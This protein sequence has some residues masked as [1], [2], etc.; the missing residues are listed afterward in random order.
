MKTRKPDLRRIIRAR[1]REARSSSESLSSPTASVRVAWSSEEYE[2]AARK[3]LHLQRIEQA[4]E[5]GE[6]A[7]RQVESS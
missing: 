6:R 5:I 4:L 2:S 3:A 1:V 7:G